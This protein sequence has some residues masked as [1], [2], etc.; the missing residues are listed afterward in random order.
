[1]AEITSAQL[2]EIKR[3]LNEIA[4]LA[5]DAEL[6]A[7]SDEHLQARIRGL[8]E[9]ANGLRMH[10]DMQLAMVTSLPQAGRGY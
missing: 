4:K 7:A 9:F 2:A 3:A 10:L 8:S 1:M 6:C 5:A